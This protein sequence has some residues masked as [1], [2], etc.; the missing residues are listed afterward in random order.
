MIVNTILQ[1]G[2]LILAH[3]DPEINVDNYT[4]MIH[5][6]RIGWSSI[7]DEVQVVFHRFLLRWL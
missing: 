5:N 3:I 7:L 2:R 4:G 6:I 1:P